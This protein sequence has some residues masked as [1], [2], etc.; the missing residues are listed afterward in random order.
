MGE[1]LKF[2]GITSLDSN[3]DRVLEEA[4]GELETVVVL[5]FTKDGAEYFASSVSDGGTVT[6]LMDRAKRHMHDLCDEI[7]GA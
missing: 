5:G 3:P 4:V 2:T 7:I 6:W 1:V